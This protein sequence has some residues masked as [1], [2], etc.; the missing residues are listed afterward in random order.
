MGRHPVRHLP[1]PLFPSTL[2][3]HHL[4][5]CPFRSGQYIPKWASLRPAHLALATSPAN[6]TLGPLVRTAGQETHRSRPLASCGRRW[7]ASPSES[8]RSSSLSVVPSVTMLTS[9]SHTVASPR[10]HISSTLTPTSSERRRDPPRRLVRARYGPDRG[11]QPVTVRGG[12]RRGLQLLTEA[13]RCWLWS[14]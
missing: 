3:D 1:R 10:P 5:L 8:M 9:T 12:G 4:L 2:A 7:Q 13:F 6:S 11:A 14:W